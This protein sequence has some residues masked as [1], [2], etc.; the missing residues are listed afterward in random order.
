MIGKLEPH[1]NVITELDEAAFAH[2]PQLT[3]L[4]LN[5]NKL[6]SAMSSLPDDVF[7]APPLRVLKLHNNDASLHRLVKGK[8]PLAGLEGCHQV[9]L[10][11]DGGDTLEQYLRQTGTF[12]SNDNGDKSE[13]WTEE[14]PKQM[15][16]EEYKQEVEKAEEK[17]L[18]PRAGQ[19]RR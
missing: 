15:T 17:T 12:L 4:H 2:N 16:E 8:G 3:T 5:H 14:G 18:P 6:S 19:R 1:K 9:D 13:W 11:Q 7:A 10:K